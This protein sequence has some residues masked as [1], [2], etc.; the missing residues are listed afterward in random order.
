MFPRLLLIALC[1]LVSASCSTQ[2]ATPTTSTSPEPTPQFANQDELDLSEIRLVC[3]DEALRHIWIDLLNEP[4]FAGVLF[5]SKLQSVYDC[6]EML[7]VSTTDLNGDGKMEKIVRVQSVC[8][9]TGNCPMAVYGFFEDGAMQTTA[10]AYDF[11]N[12]RLLFTWA[13]SIEQEKSKTNGY[14]DLMARFN[15]SSYPDNLTLYKF[16]EKVYER[17]SCF[18]QDK[19]TEKITK[20]DCLDE[21]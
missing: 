18:Q 11:R 4:K 15:G 16:N 7:E 6:S 19:M 17:R 2:Q 9:A 14:V 1:V 3:T 10:G 12:R 20:D 8:G 13:M 21:D 5:S